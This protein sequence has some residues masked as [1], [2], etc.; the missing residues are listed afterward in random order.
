MVQMVWH[1]WSV[2]QH[3]G[4]G[5]RQVLIDQPIMCLS[6]SITLHHCSCHSIQ[7][8]E[9]ITLSP[10]AEFA[11]RS[12]PQSS[13]YSATSLSANALHTPTLANAPCTLPLL[14]TPCTLPLLPTPCTLPRLPNLANYRSCQHLAHSRS[15]TLALPTPR[16]PCSHRQHLAHSRTYLHTFQMRACCSIC[17]AP[18]MDSYRLQ[19]PTQSQ[20]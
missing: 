5:G 8:P 13:R 10:H 7:H 15:D 3:V 14:P 17:P 11:Q 19:W 18:T 6:N 4:C 16:T 12:A 9:A 20:S 1:L 2:V